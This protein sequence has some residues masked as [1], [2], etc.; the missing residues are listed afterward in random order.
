[1]P[2]EV[3]F[4]AIRDMNLTSVEEETLR[5][6]CQ[7]YSNLRIAQAREVSESGIERLLTRVRLKLRIKEH[8]CPARIDLINLIWRAAWSNAGVIMK[9]VRV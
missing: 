8:G 4:L 7:G 2:E 3:F 5:F 6:V 1:M 9:E